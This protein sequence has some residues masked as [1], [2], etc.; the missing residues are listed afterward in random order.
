M[1]DGETPDPD[2]ETITLAH[3]A[4]TGK[5]AELLEEAVLPRF[6]GDD[7]S[8]PVGLG[9][10][11]DGAVHRAGEQSVVVT[12]DSH[13]VSPR[14]FPGGDLGRL[15]VS[16]TV[17]DLAVMGATTPLSLTCS[18]I[19]EEGTAV[20][21]LETLLDSMGATC[22]EAGCRITTGDTKVMGSGEID[23]IVVNTT[24]VG[25]LPDGEHISDAGL[26]V[27]DKLIVS[28]PLGDHGIALLAEREGFDL[29]G[30]LESD[31]APINDLVSAA[32]DA[33]EVTALKDPTRG[34]FA[35]ALNEMV[36]KAG[37]GATL[38]E[39]AIP[40]RDAVASAGELLGI[41]PLDVANEGRVILGVGAEDAPAVRD[42]LRDHELGREAAIIGEVTDEHTGRVV[43]DTGFG[44]RYLSEPEGVQLPRIC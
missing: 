32:L 16:G 25:L 22:E 12:T 40:V 11:D 43:L 26:S 9:A 17:N 36:R 3:G 38:D 18:L 35:T 19:V 23:G 13:V 24:G 15:A 37:V 5:T 34:G 7:T 8:T 30:D 44:R 41:D 2:G 4:G 20:S 14:T 1:S 29:D 10:L 39:T 33:G 21:E 28:G 42:A 27:G 31:V 6:E